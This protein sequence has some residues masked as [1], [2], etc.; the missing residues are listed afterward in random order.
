MGRFDRD[1]LVLPSLLARELELVCTLVVPGR[2]PSLLVCG[3]WPLAS[4]SV[5]S[6]FSL[7]PLNAVVDLAPVNGNIVRRSGSNTNLVSPNSEDSDAN[8]FADHY[9]FANTS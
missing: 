1:Q 4:V 8:V 3:P 2:K 5:L 9:G 6:L 7:L